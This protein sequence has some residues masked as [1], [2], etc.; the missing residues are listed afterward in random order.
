[1]RFDRGAPRPDPVDYMLDVARTA[2]AVAYKAYVANQLALMPG[3]TVVDVGCGPGTDLSAVRNPVGPSGLV[4]GIDVDPRMLAV[5]RERL[6]P[7]DDVRLA[8]ADAHA[9][10]FASDSIDRIR[11]DRALQ[12][13]I[14]PSRVL[15]EF[16]RVLRRDG[17]VVAAE[18]DWRTMVIDG[19]DDTISHAFVD[20]TCRDIV[21]NA[22]IGSQ[23]SQLG[24]DVGFAV[25]GIATL[26][27]VFSDFATA[28]KVFGL[29]RNA[30][31]ASRAGYISAES[32]ALWLREL[33]ARPMRA[34]VTLFVTT[35]AAG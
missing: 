16:L 32:T 21:R 6:R 5:A 25:R 34:S 18:P 29:S 15:A 8:S 35:L 30:E 3:H 4:V 10:P 22:S 1:M 11:V 19:A 24:S 33:R 20:Y 9:L 28:D 14:K 12:H 13:L 2:P 26:P 31:A 17:L 7:G 23:I 27:T